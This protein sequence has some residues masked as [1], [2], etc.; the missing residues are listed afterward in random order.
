[1]LAAP[2]VASSSM[3]GL[4][5]INPI[6]PASFITAP[7]VI[8]TPPPLPQRVDRVQLTLLVFRLLG[9]RNGELSLRTTKDIAIL[10]LDS[11]EFR[12][13]SD[14]DITLDLLDRHPTLLNNKE[15]TGWFKAMLHFERNAMQSLKR[16]L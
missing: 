5:G 7:S 16:W 9:S 12:F 15:F 8:P 6:H 13:T 1:M 2:F 10:Y 4:T 14:E 3:S 11:P